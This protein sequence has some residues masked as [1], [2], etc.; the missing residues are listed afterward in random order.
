MELLLEAGAD[1]NVSDGLHDATPLGW[2][3]FG[4][5]EQ[6]AERLRAAGATD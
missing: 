1:Y 4:G 2:A 5:Q 6:A 3:K